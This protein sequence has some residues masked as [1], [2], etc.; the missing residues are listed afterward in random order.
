M[1]QYPSAELQ[2][3]EAEVDREIRD[4]IRVIQRQRNTK[5]VA[6]VV[7]LVGALVVGSV[8]VYYAY[9]DAPSQGKAAA[10]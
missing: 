10:Q 9:Q 4:S 7:A 6:M 5:M 3:V 8:A 2:D 1:N